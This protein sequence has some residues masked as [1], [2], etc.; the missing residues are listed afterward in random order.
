MCDG[1]QYSLETYVTDTAE[2]QKVAV[3]YSSR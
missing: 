3:W 1:K 2:L